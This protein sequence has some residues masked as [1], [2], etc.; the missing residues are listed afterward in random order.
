MNTR[1]LVFVLLPWAALI[2]V[3]L[4]LYKQCKGPKEEDQKEEV[5]VV[6][7]NM[8]IDKIEAIGKLELVK[9]HIKDIIEHTT[10]MDWWPDPKVVLMV[11]GEVAGCVDLSKID[12]ND[13]S[14]QNTEITL[15]LPAPEIC[16]FKINHDESKVYNIEDK[17]MD[18]AK[19]I[20]KAYR[21]AEAQVKAGALKMGI[22]E[23]TKKNAQNLLRPML[24]N[25]TGKK[26]HIVFK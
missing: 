21:Q 25:F 24:E 3:S 19:L 5:Q 7:H 22:M 9:Y 4:V 16:Y 26:V 2:I 14:M 13:I 10:E 15:I 12:S 1:K 20:D 18:P 23:E 8:I 11:S 6:T 17:F